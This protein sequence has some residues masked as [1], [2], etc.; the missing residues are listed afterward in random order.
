MAIEAT[1]TLSSGGS[2]T[3]RTCLLRSAGTVLYRS[4]EKDLGREQG[5]EGLGTGRMAC[6]SAV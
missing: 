5:D 4:P 3:P 2:N 6:S 1:D